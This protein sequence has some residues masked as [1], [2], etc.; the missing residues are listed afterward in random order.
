MRKEEAAEILKEI[1]AVTLSPEEPFTWSSGLKSP[2]YC[3]NRLLLGHPKQRRSIAEALAAAAEEEGPD[4][5]AGTATAGIPHAAWAA[6]ILGLPMIYVRGSEKSHG[7]KN[8]IEGVLPAGAK[9]VLIEDLIS[10]GGSAFRAADAVEAA[11]GEVVSIQAIFTYGLK[12]PSLKGEAS[13]RKIKTLT[14]FDTLLG[15]ASATMAEDEV[16]SLKQWQDDPEAWSR[17][18]E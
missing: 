16:Q 4:V 6:D 1:G 15:A 2:I 13:S 5:L 3:D 11:G 14:D 12:A 17:R 8:Q 18:W 9:V 10:T 7:R